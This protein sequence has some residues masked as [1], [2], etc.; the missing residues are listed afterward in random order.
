MQWLCLRQHPEMGA[1]AANWFSNR[2]G[3][4]AAVY[5]ESIQTCQANPTGIPQ[6]YLL[7]DGEKIAAGVG[8][9]DNDFHRRRDLTPNL[10]AV[11]VEPEYRGKGLAR[12]ML[13]LACLDLAALG[14]ARCYLLTDYIGFYERCGFQFYGMVE[15]NDGQLARMYLRTLAAEV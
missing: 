3:I 8:A 2:W 6:W 1:A 9:I 5:L 12:Q 11:Y 7:L 14:I 13:D 15:D 4:P 10:C